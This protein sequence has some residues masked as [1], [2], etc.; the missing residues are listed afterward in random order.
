MIPVISVMPV[1]SVISLISVIAVIATKTL[2]GCQLKLLLCAA[3][4][5][6]H[7]S[8]LQQR[9][10]YEERGSQEPDV[11]ELDVGNSGDLAAAGWRRLEQ[12]DGGHW[13]RRME[14]TGAEGWRRQEQEDGG[15]WSRRMEETGAGGW[16]RREQEDGGDWI[17]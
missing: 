8:K 9:S 13:S 16:R 10:E 15:D 12:E 7:Q 1:I 2:R 5:K 6:V 3:G 4:D 14:E 17:K 11:N